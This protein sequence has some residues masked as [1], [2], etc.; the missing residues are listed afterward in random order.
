MLNTKTVSQYIKTNNGDLKGY[1][2]KDKGQGNFI[3]RWDMDIPEPTEQDLLDAQDS[4]DAAKII[5]DA[6]RALSKSD[7]GIA[8]LGED[9]YDILIEKSIILPSDIDIKLRDIMT[10]RK[11]ER[12]KIG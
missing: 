7:R 6:K 12:A 11:S 5:S 3:A 1:L 8:R 9:L 2:L 4:L 10:A